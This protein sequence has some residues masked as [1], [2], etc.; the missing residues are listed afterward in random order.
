MAGV[1]FAVL[2]AKFGLIQKLGSDLPF[3]DQWDAEADRLYI[4][5]AEGR[6]ELQEFFRPHNEH[7]IVFTKA[8]AFALLKLN[9]QWDSRLQMT[10]NALLHAGAII[11]LLSSLRK[12]TSE[13][14]MYAAGVLS[15]FLFGLPFSWENTLA[16][17]QSQ[18]Y[19]M[20]LFSVL[21]LTGTFHAARG[22][23]RWWGSQVAGLCAV[24]AMG[25]GFMSAVAVI[26]IILLRTLIRR[27]VSQSDIG[28]AGWNLLLVIIGLSIAVKVPGH[29]SLKSH[30]ISEFI[31]SLSYLLAWP[32]PMGALCPF[33]LIPLVLLIVRKLRGGKGATG[34]E[35]EKYDLVL[36]IA[37]WWLLQAVAIAYARG[38][39]ES[40]G[41]SPRYF[42]TLAIGTLITLILWTKVFLQHFQGPTFRKILITSFGVWVLSTTFGLY[43]QVKDAY[44][45]FLDPLGETNQTRISTVADF[46]ET[47]NPKFY[48][49]RPFFDVPYPETYRIGR[50]LSNPALRA[51]LPS[52]VRA[53]LPLVSETT[54]GFVRNGVVSPKSYPPGRTGWS[55]FG[56]PS[57]TPALFRS[58][59]VSPPLSHFLRFWVIG[60]LANAGGNIYLETANDRYPL[61]LPQSAGQAWKSVV[62]DVPNS[63]FRIVAESKPGT[64]LA[65]TQPIEFPL[66]SWFVR[67]ALKL[68]DGMMLI[69]AVLVLILLGLIVKNTLP[70]VGRSKSP[71]THFL[72]SHRGKL[73]LVGAALILFVRKTDVW[74]LPQFWA[75]DGPIFFEH[76]FHGGSSVIFA[77]YA[78]YYHFL[79]RCIAN[80]A[81][82]FDVYWAPTVYVYASIAVT[83][84]VIALLFSPRIHL[85]YK[86]LLAFSIVALPHTGEVF[87]NLTNLQWITAIGLLLISLKDDSPH[88]GDN[89]IDLVLI[90]GFGMTGPF[91]VFFVPVF[92]LRV[93]R[94]RSKSSVLWLAVAAVA[95][96]IQIEALLHFP[97]GS[98]GPLNLI[99]AFEIAG[100]RTFGR[101]LLGGQ[102]SE[103]IGIPWA[104]VAGLAVGAIV[105]FFSWRDAAYRWEKLILW[106]TFTLLIAASILRFRGQGEIL[107]NYKMGDRYFFVPMII[108]LWV[109]ILLAKR[110]VWLPVAA[111][112]VSFASNF[113]EFRFSPYQDYHWKEDAA[114][115]TAGQEVRAVLNPGFIFIDHTPVAKFDIAGPRGRLGDHVIAYCMIWIGLLI[116]VLAQLTL[117]SR[118]LQSLDAWR[119]VGVVGISG[120]LAYITFWSYLIAP[121]IGL[122]V[123]ASIEISSL[124]LVCQ[125][126]SLLGE[127]FK[128]ED[129]DY[130]SFLVMFLIGLAYIA[131]LHL[132][133]SSTSIDKLAASRF[134]QISSIDNEAPRFLAERLISGNTPETIVG[135]SDSPPLQTGLVLLTA[136][137]GRLFRLNFLSIAEAT[138]LWFQLLW[139][140][141]SWA[142]F[143]KLGFTRD[144]IVILIIILSLVGFFTANSIYV[145][146]RL[147]G[148]ALVVAALYIWLSIT[149]RTLL[150]AVASGAVAS[151]GW[152]SSGAFLFAF[153]AMGVIILTAFKTTRW[154]HVAMALLAFGFLAS[155]W[156]LYQIREERAGKP[157]FKWQ[158]DGMASTNQADSYANNTRTPRGM[159]GRK[160]NKAKTSQRPTFQNIDYS[161]IWNFDSAGITAR[162]MSQIFPVFGSLWQ[163]NLAWL[164]LPW[165]VW[166]SRQPEG[167]PQKLLLLGLLWGLFTYL[168]W[169]TYNLAYESAGSLPLNLH[170]LHLVWFIALT[171]S[172]MLWNSW[173]FA[174][175]A[176]VQLGMFAFTWLPNG[177]IATA[178]LFSPACCL[179]VFVILVLVAFVVAEKR[180]FS[181]LGESIR[182]AT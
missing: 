17:F 181:T 116:I 137:L 172:V 4:P 62:V 16:G 95:A 134:L 170:P 12:C 91:I 109:I 13:R 73:T 153:V 156:A 56:R 125:R 108:C 98:N 5:A 103:S 87:L 86:P 112:I 92:I 90:F 78:G 65:F 127:W 161:H 29:E 51:I 72:I 33:T 152:L 124:I 104:A 61:D 46:V 102:L 34:S 57:T 63:P 30:S 54:I 7:H 9:G 175:L 139:I 162:R 117:W 8:L 28:L 59:K 100:Y 141:V 178:P 163:W 35:D 19:F 101:L 122:L 114:K 32:A 40:H 151:L 168:G 22:S 10:V 94:F 2:G 55:S 144:R 74:I 39:G 15:I 70:Y 143:R 118:R 107:L 84:G 45:N 36:S 42:D 128:T 48:Q 77:P 68:S 129:H 26:G 105:F 119:L 71:V 52:S 154:S 160:P 110:W 131:V 133:G 38:G 132:Y 93:I 88:L 75:E 120:F 166:K 135:S 6:L 138:G 60:D 53:T 115:I 180:S 97:S 18:F 27:R 49:S 21:H 25:S 126:R 24:F 31:A 147:G 146:P 158:L 64:S 130:A 3:W 81:T 66:G 182:K 44:R 69:G 96:S 136:P 82:H 47:H 20:M 79:L 14:W 167:Q 50:L 173:M 176:L 142:F 164:L 41:L 157:P 113:G 174:G 58:K 37:C 106:I 83:L 89:I 148:A 165:L 149:P 99:Q 179:L 85:P 171:S 123:S 80:L 43:Y 145:W 140:P 159:V 169:R 111:L 177:I 76:A 121:A 23:T 1:F 155:P 67:H 150:T 11:V